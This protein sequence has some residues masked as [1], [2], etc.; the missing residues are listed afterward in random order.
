MIGEELLQEWRRLKQEE[1][2]A[3]EQ[4]KA[5]EEKII[6]DE[7][8]GQ[9]V[10]TLTIFDDGVYKLKVTGNLKYSIDENVLEELFADPETSEIITLVTKTKHELNA[11]AFHSLP[12]DSAD[13]IRPAISAR[14]L[15]PTF[16]ITKKE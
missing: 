9:D 10:G 15:R 1:S 14:F 13:K 12:L 6:Q 8:I 3:A 7:K 11:R 5:L 2:D 16:A 4:R